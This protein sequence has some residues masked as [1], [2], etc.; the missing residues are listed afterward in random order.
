MKSHKLM[1]AD[2]NLKRVFDNLS[3]KDPI[4]KGLIKAMKDI[5]ENFMVGRL[6]TKDTHNKNRIKKILEKYNSNNIRVYNLPSAW[7]MLYSITRSEDIKIVAIILDWVSH[8]DYERLL[9]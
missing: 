5:K 4:K 2:K 7:R 3:D 6:I 8:K 1:F 9:K